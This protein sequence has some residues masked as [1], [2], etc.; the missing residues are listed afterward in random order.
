MK[1]TISG[2]KVTALVGNSRKYEVP[3]LQES[4]DGLSEFERVLLLDAEKRAR[5]KEEERRD[6]QQKSPGLLTRMTKL[7]KAMHSPMQNT[8]QVFVSLVLDRNHAL[9]YE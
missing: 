4:A 1:S 6:L 9:A 5:F 7:T 3:S 8:I 2:Q